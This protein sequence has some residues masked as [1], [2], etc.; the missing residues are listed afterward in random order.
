[1]EFDDKKHGAEAYHEDS[2]VNMDGEV[3]EGSHF[4]DPAGT[5]RQQ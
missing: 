5:C 2:E 3:E 1:M 4:E